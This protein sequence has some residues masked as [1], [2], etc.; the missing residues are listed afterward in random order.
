M[1]LW[2]ALGLITVGDKVPGRD[3]PGQED[4]SGG[5]SAVRVCWL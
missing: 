1:R 5:E 4:P 3:G 2:T